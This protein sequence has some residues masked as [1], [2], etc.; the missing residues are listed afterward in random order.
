MSVENLDYQSHSDTFQTTG[1]P[2]NIVNVRVSFVLDDP[3]S[4]IQ[5]DISGDQYFWQKAA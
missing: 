4:F 1:V 5:I 2:D 3:Q